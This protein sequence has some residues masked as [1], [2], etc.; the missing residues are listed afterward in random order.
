VD[1]SS[2]NDEAVEVKTLSEILRKRYLETKNTRNAGVTATKQNEML[3]NEDGN[4]ATEFYSQNVAERGRKLGNR[5]ECD[6]TC[7]R[8]RRTLGS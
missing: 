5:E 3:Q 1:G 7:C 2:E 4:S 6:E 8:T